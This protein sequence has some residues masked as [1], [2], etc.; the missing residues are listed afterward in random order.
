LKAIYQFEFPLTQEKIVLQI[1]QGIR[2]VRA[3]L[4]GDL[5]LRRRASEVPVIAN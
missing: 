4:V 1:P 5:K 3:V 2:P